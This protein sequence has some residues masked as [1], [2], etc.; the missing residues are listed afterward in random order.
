MAWFRAEK[1]R[2]RQRFVN[3]L[4]R[5]EDYVDQT[6]DQVIDRLIASGAILWYWSGRG[7]ELA[8]AYRTK[9]DKTKIVIGVPSPEGE[10]EEWCKCM[11]KKLRREFDRNG[12]DDFYATQLPQYKSDHMQEFAEYIDRICWEVDEDE[13]SEKIRRIRFRRLSNRKNEDNVFEGRGK[14]RELPERIKKTREKRRQR[15]RG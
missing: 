5:C 3:V 2:N 4:K 11:I 6:S 8:L 13:K 14:D 15:R 1:G 12:I 10:G 7:F 9:D